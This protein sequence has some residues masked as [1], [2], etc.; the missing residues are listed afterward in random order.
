M[1]AV[2]VTSSANYEPRAEMVGKILQSFGH[3]VLWLESDFIHREKKKKT[4][5]VAGH[6]YIDTVAYKKNMS[7]R[8]LYSR[9]DF[10]RKVVEALKDQPIDLLYVMIPANSLVPAAAEL[11]ERCHARLVLDIIDLW[12]ESLPLKRIKRFWPVQYWRRLRDDHLDAADLIFTECRLYQEILGLRKNPRL[13][14]TGVMYW[15]KEREAEKAPV[16]QQDKERI[17]MA[18]LG[19]ANH[20]IDIDSIVYILEKV[21]QR[22][23]VR[24]H[25]VGDGESRDIFL[26]ELKDHGIETKYYGTVYDE[27]K[28]RQVFEKCSFG[29]N[30][31]KD[32]VCVGLTMKS[33]DYLCYGLPLINNIPGDTWKLVE[34]YG[35]GVNCGKGK[36]DECAEMILE[37]S[38][39]I[40]EKRESIRRLYERLFTRRS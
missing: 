7:V 28:K 3:E 9:Y 32:S 24:L 31:M 37:I 12:P 11:K 38:E 4:R 5:R 22:K 30:M 34:Q 15:A 23:K 8:R 19:S 40:Q 25:I 2:V 35:I 18:Y 21:N 13:K 29:I 6:Q 39:T 26:Q 36:A 14:Q 33:I 20:I 17:H 16:F 27:E 1:K 10:A